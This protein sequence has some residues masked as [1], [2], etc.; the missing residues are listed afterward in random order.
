M[1][2]DGRSITKQERE[3]IDQ[4]LRLC[5]LTS[6]WMRSAVPILCPDDTA[7]GRVY[8][9]Y[10][11]PE[12]SGLIAKA[13]YPRR[14]PSQEAKIL[15]QLEIVGLEEVVPKIKEQIFIQNDDIYVDEFLVMT[16]L[17]G[18]DF[19]SKI[20]PVSSLFELGRSLAELHQAF[21][22]GDKTGDTLGI[23]PRRIQN[24]QTRSL[25]MC[26]NAVEILLPSALKPKLR[27][28]FSRY[29]EFDS[30]PIHGDIHGGN[31]IG[32][33]N[34]RIGFCDFETVQYAHPGFDL[35]NFEWQDKLK[36]A[37]GYDQEN[38]DPIDRRS[39]STVDILSLVFELTRHETRDHNAKLDMLKNR[40]NVPYD[41]YADLTPYGLEA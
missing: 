11:S 32:L 3:N 21:S 23:D 30:V 41:Y 18:I 24:Y 29:S 13:I 8:L 28:V 27:A 25:S 4:K 7:H 35:I 6:E 26:V 1:K 40:L 37:N 9:I 14:N 39:L 34:G 17:V 10:S 12:R 20:F 22:K 33:K 31:I 19:R 16:K 38:R 2:Y 5:P 36:V 15:E